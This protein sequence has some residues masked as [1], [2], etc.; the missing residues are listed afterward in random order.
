MSEFKTIN[1]KNQF[2]LTRNELV[3]NI[4]AELKN[5]NV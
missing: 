5:N 3:L 1:E 2:A 4:W